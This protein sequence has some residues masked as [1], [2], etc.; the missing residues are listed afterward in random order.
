[1]NRRDFLATLPLAIAASAIPDQIFGEKLTRDSSTSAQK[2]ARVAPAAN[3]LD[4]ATA[5]EAAEAIRS[6]KV[7]S[8]ELTQTM[9]ARMD[10]YNGQLNAFAYQTR[11]QALAQAKKADV[12]LAQSKGKGATLGVFHGVPITVKESFAVE[13]HPCT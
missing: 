11:D 12:M 13:G 5:L 7:S 6:R 1:M 8:V 4:F 10:R 2:A 3:D 9:F